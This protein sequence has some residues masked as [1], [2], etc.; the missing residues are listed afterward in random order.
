MATIDFYNVKT[1]KKESF[2]SDEIQRTTFEKKLKDGGTQT[3][4][5]LRAKSKAGQQ[6]T[7]FCNQDTWNSLKASRT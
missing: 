4:Y 5:A 2:D 3:I 7:K 1:R 6:L